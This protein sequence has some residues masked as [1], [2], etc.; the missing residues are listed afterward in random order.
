MEGYIGRELKDKIDN[1]IIFQ[2]VK[3]AAENPIS[4]QTH[5]CDATILIDVCKSI[6]DARNGG[7]LSGSKYRK[8]I[9]QAQ[10]I[11]SAWDRLSIGD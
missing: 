10:I 9:N 1:P 2:M 3:P 7:K 5:G 6:L 4:E 8:M 11:L